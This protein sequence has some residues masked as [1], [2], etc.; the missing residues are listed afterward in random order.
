M[1]QKLVTTPARSKMMAKIRGTGGKSETMLSKKLWHLGVRYRRNYKALP[2]TPDIVITKYKVAVFIDGE[3][4][5]GFDWE[6][7]KQRIHRNHDFWITKIT[8]NILRDKRQNAELKQMGWTVLR[9]WERGEVRANADKCV[10]K[11]ILVLRDKGWQQ[12]Y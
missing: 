1:S 3:F 9:F 8:N 5:H 11:I 6:N 10:Q 2:G 7:Q 4:W 12:N